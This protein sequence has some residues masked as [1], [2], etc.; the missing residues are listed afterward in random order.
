MSTFDKA[1]EYI[2]NLPPKGDFVP[3]TEMRLEFYKY[4]KQA[5]EGDNSKE[6]PGMIQVEARKKWDAWNSIKGMSKDEAEKKYIEA[7][8]KLN[9]NWA[10]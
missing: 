9:P 3:S 5:K 7:L 6:Q 1:A 4:Y 8:V 2:A 10:T